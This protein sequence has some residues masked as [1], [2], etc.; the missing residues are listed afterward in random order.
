M[1]P[2]VRHRGAARAYMVHGWPRC[3]CQA[4]ANSSRSTV[5]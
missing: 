1:L 5:A 4:M 3:Q 2:S